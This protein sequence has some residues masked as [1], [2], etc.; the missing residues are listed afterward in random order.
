MF[1]QMVPHF[2]MR[3]F[4]TKEGEYRYELGRNHTHK[5]LA[6]TVLKEKRSGPRF[7]KLMD[8]PMNQ[9]EQLRIQTRKAF[10]SK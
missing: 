1:Y 9:V 2:E 3:H 8:I 7:G 6:E 5:I 4:E 10:I